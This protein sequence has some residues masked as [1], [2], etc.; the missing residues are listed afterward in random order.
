MKKFFALILV[1]CLAFTGFVSYT[2]YKAPEAPAEEPVIEDENIDA[3]MGA[4]MQAI[5]FDAIYALHEPDEIVMTIGEKEISWDEYFYV[6]HALG[7]SIMNEL[8]SYLLY[9]GA[10]PQWTDPIGNAAGDTY[11]SYITSMIPENLRELTAIRGFAEENGVELS[12]EYLQA[13]EADHEAVKVSVLGDGASEEEF[14]EYLK[15]IY[16]SREVYDKFRFIDYYYDASAATL[17]GAKGE[18]VSDEDAMSYVE[19]YGY[20]YADHILVKTVDDSYQPLDEAT[21]AEKKAQAEEI[22]AQLSACEDGEEKV[23][24]FYELKNQY[25]EDPGAVSNPE[26]YVFTTGQ[27]VM[28]FEEGYLNL[29]DGQ[30]SGIVESEY[31]YHIIYRKAITADT[32]MGYD[33][34]GE[35]VT[36]RILYAA[37]AYTK[38]LNDY[39]A[40]LEIKYAEGF[41]IPNILDY[42]Y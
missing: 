33:S 17:Y 7:N 12:E 37:E 32:A 16:M 35:A 13:A 40:S 10:A 38:S 29:E 9:F 31:G 6:L 18:N 26:G 36:P 25:T 24:L 39:A 3:A 30:I 41:E 20:M 28:A 8:Q 14:D 1:V 4:S 11:A 27:M 2:N 23:A 19:G 34:T 15:S 42:L 21:V 22:A 5:N